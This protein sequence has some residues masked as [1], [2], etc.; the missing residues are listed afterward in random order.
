MLDADSWTREPRLVIGYDGERDSCD[1]LA[2]G[3]HLIRDIRAH[4]TVAA[5]FPHL[6]AHAGSE[7]FELALGRKSDPIFAEARTQLKR[8]AGN[9]AARERALGGFPVPRLLSRLA[10]NE[11]A[12]LLV[13]GSTRRAPLARALLGSTGDRVIRTAPCPVAIVPHGYAERPSEPI[14]LVG[15]AYDGTA[16]GERAV[17]QAA[18]LARAASARLRM[19]AVVEPIGVADIAYAGQTPAGPDPRFSRE[20]LER[21]TDDLLA[22]LPEDLDADSLFLSGDPA[23]ELVEGVADSVDT[24]VVGSHAD[25]PILRAFLGSVSTSIM[26]SATFPVIVVPPHA[27]LGFGAAYDEPR[28]RLV[29]RAPAQSHSAA[30]PTP[31]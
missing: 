13:L 19:I 16:G 4:L 22:S 25:A 21:V 15:A 29:P 27:A 8:T 31:A 14:K 26:R 12:D 18:A 28:L 11:D 7:A 24:L 10:S 23:E 3:A 5:A 1:A 17:R 2:F 6:R 30:G 20:I 9:V